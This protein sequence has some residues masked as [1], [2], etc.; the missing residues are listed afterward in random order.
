ML[1][2]RGFVSADLFEVGAVFA[3]G[4]LADQ[5]AELA[6]VDEAAPEGGFF[7]AADFYALAFFDGLHVRGSVMQAAAGAGVEPGKAAARSYAFRSTSLSSITIPN[8]LTNIDA[9]AFYNCTS[10]IAID[11]SGRKA[12]L[13]ARHYR[14]QRKRCFQTLSIQDR[15]TPR[16]LSCPRTTRFGS[17]DSAR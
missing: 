8:N 16:P 15:Q 4:E 14:F 11:R 13:K 10:L 7:R 5:G 9:L 1:A 2:A 6:E 3:I 12:D 17:S